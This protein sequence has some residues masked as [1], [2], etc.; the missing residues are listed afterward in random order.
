MEWLNYHIKIDVREKNHTMDDLHAIITGA[1]GLDDKQ[2]EV[3]K[4]LL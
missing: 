3:T 1:L 2:V 4:L